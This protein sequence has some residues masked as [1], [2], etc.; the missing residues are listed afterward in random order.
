M[1]IC[2]CVDANVTRIILT[3]INCDPFE[4][5]FVAIDG[6]KAREMRFREYR[7]VFHTVHLRQLVCLLASFPL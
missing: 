4:V 1:D 5:C 3:V 6:L 7:R 2:M